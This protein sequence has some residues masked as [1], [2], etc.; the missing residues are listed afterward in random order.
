MRA[1]GEVPCGSP[2]FVT[3]RLPRPW[4]HCSNCDGY[5]NAIFTLAIGAIDE[6]NNR[7]YYS[8]NCASLLAVAYSSGGARS[9][10]TTDRRAGCTSRHGGTSAAA[11]MAAG[12]LALALEANPNLT[13][14]DVQHCVVTSAVEV[15]IPTSGSGGGGGGGVPGGGGGAAT[16]IC[17]SS[18]LSPCASARRPEWASQQ[19]P[20]KETPPSATPY[21][22]ASCVR[23]AA[24]CYVVGQT[25]S[26]S[27]R[28][29]VV[30]VQDVPSPPQT[31]Q[32]ST[33]APPPHTPI[34]SSMQSLAGS[35]SQAAQLSSTA[36]PCG[37]PAQSAQVA[38]VPPQ[39]PQ[40]SLV[41]SE[42]GTPSQPRSR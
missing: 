37:V 32:V 10:T 11:P 25:P 33:T 30:V 3:Y 27:V 42:L 19:P 1:L 41:A 24:Y 22:A 35:A 21:C 15:S 17:R 13:W 38:P 29:V 26:T 31:L 36:L 34:Q 39:T 9:I 28:R 18:V 12:I 20:A 5:A 7:P 40:A 4:P 23:S 8:E 6:Y 14:R 2:L 16:S